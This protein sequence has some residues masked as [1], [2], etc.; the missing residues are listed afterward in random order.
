MEASPANPTSTGANQENS[1]E[2]LLTEI[3][4][5]NTTL[6]KVASDVS[7][8]LQ[9]RIDEA[10]S[11]IA[12]VEDSSARYWYREWKNCGVVLTTTRTEEDKRTLGW[13]D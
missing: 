3:V 1:G 13:L 10:E 9:T 7:S 2:D 5:I 12:N 6:N 11:R 8:A 4:K